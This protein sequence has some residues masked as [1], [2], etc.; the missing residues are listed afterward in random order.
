MKDKYN[1][2]YREIGSEKRVEI[3]GHIVLGGIENFQMYRFRR[4]DEREDCGFWTNA[5]SICLI[6]LLNITHY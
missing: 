4:Y 1:A 3:K 5:D 6:C 2:I